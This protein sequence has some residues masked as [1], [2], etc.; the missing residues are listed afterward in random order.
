MNPALFHL[1]FF[2]PHSTPALKLSVWSQGICLGRKLSVCS[3][4]TGPMDRSASAEVV[5]FQRPTRHKKGGATRQRE[6][7]KASPRGG[8]SANRILPPRRAPRRSRP[9]APLNQKKGERCGRSIF[10]N[11][12]IQV[13]TLFHAGMKSHFKMR[14]EC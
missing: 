7:A 11:C 1:L 8:T 14:E 10:A 6:Y 12:Q 13:V 5:R 4:K 9:P 2:T 3:A